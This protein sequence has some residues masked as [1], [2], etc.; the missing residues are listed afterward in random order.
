MTRHCGA[1]GRPLHSCAR[2]LL[3]Q[4]SLKPRS[5]PSNQPLT[6]LEPE[7]KGKQRRNTPIT[8]RAQQKQT[9]ELLL[10][11]VVLALSLSMAVLCAPAKH[12][13]W[14]SRGR[15]I[16]ISGACLCA[17]VSHIDGERGGLPLP[18]PSLPPED[19]TKKRTRRGSSC[20]TAVQISA[21]EPHTK[22]KK[23]CL[24]SRG[25]SV[26]SRNAKTRRVFPRKQQGLALLV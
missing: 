16:N 5:R 6:F 3:P 24:V 10:C 2:Y 7:I 8:T 12:V 1:T 14:R 11:Y 25:R 15:R 26:G 17:S 13:V 18:L 23:W 20:T 21:N 22:A 9:N 4:S 19:K